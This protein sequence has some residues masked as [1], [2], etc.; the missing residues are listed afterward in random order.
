[1]ININEIKENSFLEIKEEKMNDKKL[2][3]F[4]GRLDDSSK[5]L[6]RAID[7]CKEI[8]DIE[9]WI[10]GNGP[11]KNMY[12]DYAKGNKRIK[13]LG[14]KKNPYPYIAKADYIILTSEYEGFPVVYLEALALN[15]QIITTINTS[16][17]LINIKDYAYI[18]SKDGNKM[19]KEVKEI[20]NKGPKYTEIDLDSIQAKRIKNF[21]KIF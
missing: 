20:L 7:L 9:L 4:I 19:I 5:K 14:L 21:E 12:I 13:F 8:S 1:M 15:K 3:V 11:D 18:I 2:F 10:I 17:D 16:D 6:K